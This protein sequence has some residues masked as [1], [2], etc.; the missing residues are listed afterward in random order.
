MSTF[1][2]LISR[3]RRPEYT[4]EN[5]C[6]PCTVVNVAITATVGV[7]VTGALW[8]A[9]PA[10]AL[11]V[12]T[13]VVAVGLALVVL[14]G[15]VV[16]GTPALT[17]RYLPDRVLAKFDKRPMTTAGVGVAS[18]TAP[19]AE[20]AADVDAD[21][22]ADAQGEADADAQGDEVAG[23]PGASSGQFESSAESF[24]PVDPEELL[25]DAGAVEP[26]PDGSDLRLTDEFESDWRSA[27]RRLRDGDERLA[28][29]DGLLVPDD[30]VRLEV[31][32]DRPVA[33]DG[34][35]RLNG[36]PSDAAMAADLS[37]HLA[38][39]ARTD[40]WDDV[41]TTQRLGILQALRS[42]LAVCPVCEG[43][44]STTE[45][46][47]ESC[48]RDWEVIAVRCTDC[49]AHFLELDPVQIGDHVANERPGPTEG[50]FTR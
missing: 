8:S 12:G 10:V 35:S 14:R 18:A 46:V 47:V 20:R 38:I 45:D 41:G 22:N 36:W 44:V 32:Q 31:E 21:G 9:G 16:P 4:G 23:E 3:L 39:A 25:F 6:I 34:R 50:G 48:C 33:Y 28:A 5:R 2:A 42:F 7:V 19:V 43:A 27:A 13:G 11:P 30:S 29:L 15:Y 37:A 49:G 24:E 17:R 26:T 40:R 1:S